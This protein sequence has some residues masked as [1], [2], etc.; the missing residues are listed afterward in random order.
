MDLDARIAVIAAREEHYDRLEETLT[1]LRDAVLDYRYQKVLG[2]DVFKM[3]LA[4]PK[5][6]LRAK[7]HIETFYPEGLVKGLKP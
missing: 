1:F 4:D 2:Y 3:L 7:K 5:L 6:K